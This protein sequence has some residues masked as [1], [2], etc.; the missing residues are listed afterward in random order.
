MLSHSYNITNALLHLLPC[1][2]PLSSYV[3]LFS[4]YF[5]LNHRYNISF[6]NS[7]ICVYKELGHFLYNH[8][9]VITLY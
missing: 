5:K 9:S 2:P 4:K 6:P 8:S 7:S 3:L 1:L